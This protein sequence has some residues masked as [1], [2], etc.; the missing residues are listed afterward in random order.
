M[1][2]DGVRK[3]KRETGEREP[4]LDRFDLYE[5]AVTS[6]L[7]LAR[8]LKAVHGRRPRVLGEDFSGSGALSRA[9]VE[10]DSRNQAILVDRDREAL[11]RTGSHPRLKKLRSDVMR[12]NERCDILACTNFP[13]CYWHTRPELIAYLR[14]ARSRLNRRG[15]FIADLYG[16]SDAFT[17][18]TT[19][20]KLRRP[21]GKPLWYTWEQREADPISGRVLNALHFRTPGPRGRMQAFKNAFTYDWRLWSIPELTEAMHDAGFGNIDVYDSLGDAV[22]QHGDLHVRPAAELDD[23]FVVYI[24]ARR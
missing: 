4:A 12:A 15:V 17:P 8:F 21:D 16:G 5:L 22:D 7:P 11:S 9:W 19:M 2:P 1:D 3:K 18:G 14:H 10:I 13:I 20:Q 24:V 6:P 23:P